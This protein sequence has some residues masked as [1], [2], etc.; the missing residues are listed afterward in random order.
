MSKTFF[1]PTR[2]YDIIAAINRV[3]VA[4]GSTVNAYKAT[5]ADYNGHSVTVGFNKYR[6]YWIA[7]HFWAGRNVLCRGQFEDCLKAA[8]TE[9]NRGALGSSIFVNCQTP[10]QEKLCESLFLIEWSK[11]REEEHWASF[12]DWRYQYVGVALRNNTT[13]HLINATSLDDYYARCRGNR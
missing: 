2:P 7:E 6:G 5:N 11:E 9:Y 12:A 3:A 1:A 10:E 8:I 13:H 4:T